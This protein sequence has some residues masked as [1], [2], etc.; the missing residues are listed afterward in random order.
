M[1]LEKTVNR[2]QKERYRLLYKQTPFMMIA[3]FV[4]G[5]ALV[6]LLHSGVPQNYLIIW[7]SMLYLFS[8]GIVVLYFYLKPFFAQLSTI[9]DGYFYY[10]LPLIFGIIWGLTGYYF[11]Y[12]KLN[13]TFC[14]FNYF[15]VWHDCRRS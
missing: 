5:F 10:Y 9:P 12:T 4:A 15:S 6:A 2:I 1:T 3:N 11:F 14:F 8:A 13:Y 7:L